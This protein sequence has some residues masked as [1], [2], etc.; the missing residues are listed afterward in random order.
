MTLFL[1]QRLDLGITYG[2]T[3]G[4]RFSTAINAQADGVEMLRALW[5]QPL[6]LVNLPEIIHDETEL[7]YLLNFHT[8]TKGSL[9]GFRIRDWSDWFATGQ[10]VGT[11]TGATQHW[12]LIKTYTVGAYSVKR[13]ITKPVAGSVV[14]YANGVAQETGWTIDPTNGHLTTNLSGALTVDFDFDV[15]VRF[16]QDK[17]SY[18][19]EA[20]SPTRKLFTLQPVTLTEIRVTPYAYPSLDAFPS[21]L[22]EVIDLGKDLG[23]VGGP[24]FETSIIATSSEWESRKARLTNPLGEWNIG[25]RNLDKTELAYWIALFRICKGMAIAFQFKDWQDEILKM[26][27]FSEDRIS[28]RFDAY[29]STDE[30]VIF[31]L[32][33]IGIKISSPFVAPPVIFQTETIIYNPG[34]SETYYYLAMTADRYGQYGESDTVVDTWSD[35][36]TNNYLGPITVSGFWTTTGP[37]S[38]LI[39]GGPIINGVDQSFGMIDWV[40]VIVYPRSV[41]YPGLSTIGP[42]SYQILPATGGGQ[43]DIIQLAAT[44][45]TA[46][47]SVKNS[48]QTIIYTEGIDYEVVSL[49]NGQI[50]PLT[51]GAIADGQTLIIGYSL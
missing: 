46:I 44:G 26:V 47:L 34:Q 51:G 27:R 38:L 33:G 1:E 45:L 7:E 48:N 14:V 15:P 35:R 21:A 11:G 30:Q 31:N 6:I 8:D 23:T 16:E 29:R 39:Y 12:Q 5:E 19:F 25:D 32:G 22:T 41:D 13:A 50:R 43:R 36:T 49:A 18:K 9:Y 42:I 37:F 4:P 10:V 40:E 3:Y 2:A 24:T 17:I 28:F 20:I